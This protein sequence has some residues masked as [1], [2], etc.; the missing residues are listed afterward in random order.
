ML[1]LLTLLQ[2][3]DSMFPIGGFTQSFGLEAYVE[4]NIVNDVATAGVYAGNMLRYS[5]FFNDAA[6]LYKAWDLSNRKKAWKNIQELDYMVSATKSPFEIRQASKKLA[7]RF[8]KVTEQMM[9]VPKASK[10][11]KEI[12]EAKLHGHHSIAFGLYANASKIPLDDTLT[13]Y[14]YNTLAGIV[15]N[16]AKL[17]PISQ[18]DGQKLL[19][20]MQPL[21]HELVKNQKDI[22]DDEI[23]LSFIGHDIRCMQ[24]EKQYTRLYI[25]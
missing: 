13:A 7:I 14:Y 17:V 21:I 10:Y 3:N 2:I 23:G 16:C 4:Q 15:T 22:Q 12:Q 11:L 20:N 19:F 8:L 25:S 1:P 24:H 18:N 9:P 5:T 6:F